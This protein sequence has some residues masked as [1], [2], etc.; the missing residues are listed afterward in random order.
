MVL[1]TT[2]QISGGYM[3]PFKNYSGKVVRDGQTDG[4]THETKTEPV[5]ADDVRG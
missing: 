4:R 2:H 3:E 5:G 1:C